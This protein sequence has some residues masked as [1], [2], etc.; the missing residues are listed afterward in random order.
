MALFKVCVFDFAC[1]LCGSH[2]A[3][4]YERQRMIPFSGPGPLVHFNAPHLRL[5]CS[6]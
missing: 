4:L 3:L 2:P 5:L 6:G 1:C